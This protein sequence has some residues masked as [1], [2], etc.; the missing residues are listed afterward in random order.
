MVQTL[1]DQADIENNIKYEI[2]FTI[3]ELDEKI[4]KRLNINNEKL[5]KITKRLKIT[6][7]KLSQITERLDITD[8]KVEKIHKL[9]YSTLKYRICDCI[10]SIILFIVIYI[11]VYLSK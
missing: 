8:E 7:E 6:D 10:I 4:T 2:S 1:I 11:K 5:E 3:N 9:F